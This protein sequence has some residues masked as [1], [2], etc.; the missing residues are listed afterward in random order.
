M[1]TDLAAEIASMEQQL[2]ELLA[3]HQQAQQAVEQTE[4]AIHQLRGAL[5]F[6]REWLKVQNGNDPNQE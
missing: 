6:A 3:R 5:T 1:T 2:R 4:A